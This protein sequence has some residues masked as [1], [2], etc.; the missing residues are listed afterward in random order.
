VAVLILLAIPLLHAFRPDAEIAALAGRVS[1]YMT[2]QLFAYACLQLPHPEVPTGAEQGL[3]HGR[4]VTRCI[5]ASCVR[6]I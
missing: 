2:P 4:R 6:I 5:E 1:L 3:D